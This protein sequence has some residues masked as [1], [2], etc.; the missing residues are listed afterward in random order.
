MGRVIAERAARYL[1]PVLLELGGKAPL[2]LRDDA[3]L[4]AAV[5]AAVFGAFTVCLRFRAVSA[6]TRFRPSR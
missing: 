6:L 5:D 4:D 1:K 3:D 2:I